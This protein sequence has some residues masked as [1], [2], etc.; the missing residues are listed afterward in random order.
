VLTLAV[1]DRRFTFDV[2]RRESLIEEVLEASLEKRA[3]P[4]AKQIIECASRCRPVDTA[5]AW[6]TDVRGEV[7][8]FEERLPSAYALA[9]S[10]Q[11]DAERYTDTHCWVFTPRSFIDLLENLAR[12][13]L[14]PFSVEAVT[15]TAANDMEF[16]AR[17]VAVSDRSGILASVASARAALADAPVPAEET[18]PSFRLLAASER[19]RDAEA[20]AAVAE[21]EA[22][23]LRERLLLLEQSTSW[24]ATAPLRAISGAL[25]R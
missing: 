24:R 23:R 21:Q 12:L 1:P 6:R 22:A 18:D 4:S 13:D 5:E 17:L 16:F 15:P 3:R 7:D 8:L 19:A 2:S 14:L 20:R 10:L 25:R 9:R 11:T